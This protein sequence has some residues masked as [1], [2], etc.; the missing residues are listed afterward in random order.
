MPREL[1]QIKAQRYQAAV[2]AWLVGERLVGLAAEPLGDTYDASRHAAFVGSIQFDTGD[3]AQNDLL[4][5]A[6]S[7]EGIGNGPPQ[8]EMWDHPA[9]RP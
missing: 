9:H 4:R 5:L 6:A 7:A 2:A 3:I 1:S 8:A